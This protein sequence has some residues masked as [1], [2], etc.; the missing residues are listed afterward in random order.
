M[1]E[2]T[3]GSG[4]SLSIT[5]VLTSGGLV[6]PMTAIG[7]LIVG[8]T[9]GDPVALPI[10]ANNF[11]LTS[12]GTTA[13]WASV[14][15]GTGDVTGPAS[16]ITTGI[17]TFNG[18][19]G[20]IIQSPSNA[21]VTS[22]G[23]GTFRSLQVA[24]TSGNGVLQLRNQ[25]S[26]VSGI[27]NYTSINSNSG[28]TG[29]QVILGSAAYASSLIF[30]ATLAR[31][32]TLPDA[33]G[34]FAFRDVANSWSAG[35]KQTFAPDATNAG[36]NVGTLAGQP[37]SPANGDLVY[38]SSA[39]ALQAYINGAWVSLGAGGGGSS[40]LSAITA[41]TAGN[42]INNLNFA[43]VWNWSTLNTGTGFTFG[44]TAL[45]SGS[46][47]ALTHTT[48]A[49]T[50]NLASYTSTGITTGN[51]LNLGISGS[52]A[53]S[54]DNLVITNS[55]T[56]NTSGRGLDISITGTTTN[57]LTF[58][59][60][61]SN[62]KTATGTGVNTAL[63]LTASGAT[64]NYALDVTAGIVRMAASTAS[65]PH[66]LFTAGAAALTATTNG[67]LSYAT[68][69]SNSSFYLYKDSGVTT[70]LTTA[71]NP[72]FAVGSASGVLIA[73]TSGNITK[74]ADLTALGI[75]AAYD[76]VTIPGTTTA[77]TTM[78]SGSLVGS[79]TLPANFFA[80]GKTIEFRASGIF[81]LVAARTLTLRVSISSLNI[82][83]VIDHGNL[84]TNRFFDFLVSVTCKAISGSNSTYIYTIASNAVHDGN[85]GNIL[86]GNGADSGSL[87]I[88]TASTIATD[89]SAFF[90]SSD[91]TD[92][93][94]IY[95]AS[96]QYLN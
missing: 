66:M 16:S 36:I 75:F 12:N 61:I 88:N 95:Q 79:K 55:S 45:T 51:L 86:F 28:G 93:I 96:A 1:Q 57:A 31:T 7:D 32:Y 47:L 60:V 52:T 42:T 58:G 48:S 89:M 64:T 14:P 68:V 19:T 9:S 33:S 77:A 25:S 53:T 17:A 67:M 10:G 29:L 71:R 56:A 26:A 70:I 74:S 21:T 65:L 50:G 49:L 81:T 90:D 35:V 23:D 91:A 78:V 6:N 30:S 87:A 83:I 82:D 62:T 24:G 5:G 59:A 94:T 43:Q 13:V 39:T 84:I 11:V 4:L 76:T 69:S 38:N 37:T 44:S 73:D 18:T 85:G 8:S 20:K 3:I 27:A 15:S 41:A 46:L 72:D 2:V 40:A 63:Q 22:S 92:T 80:V 54:A 34:T